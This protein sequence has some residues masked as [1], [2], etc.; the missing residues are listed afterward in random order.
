MAIMKNLQKMSLAA[1]RDR[2]RQLAYAKE[3][4]AIYLNWVNNLDRELNREINEILRYTG[5]VLRTESQAW[6]V[7]YADAE[8]ISLSEASKRATRADIEALQIKAKQ[9]VKD[10]DFSPIAN[11]KMREYNYSMKMSRHELLR[12]AF[13]LELENGFVKID[14]LIYNHLQMMALSELKRQAGLLG[15]IVTD[16]KVYEMKARLIANAS[17]HGA[18]FSERVWQN[19]KELNKILANGIKRSI[20]QGRHPTAWMNEMSKHLDRGLSGSSYSLKRLAVTESTRVQI[21]A[22]KEVYRLNG[23]GQFM[24]VC[25]PTACDICI[26]FDGVAQE[27]KDMRVGDTAPPFHPNCKCSTAVVERTRDE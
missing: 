1:Q 16:Q 11:R 4:E 17:F 23:Y 14:G 24:V 5:E 10:R 13:E 3:R 15:Q 26:P 19:Q 21:A 2:N 18:T 6:L 8:G 27:I 9:Y 22:Q 12:R 20:M 7:R 25:E